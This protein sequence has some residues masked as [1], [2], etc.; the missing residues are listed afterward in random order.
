MMSGIWLLLDCQKKVMQ[1]G[2]L[3]RKIVVF[4]H[5][6]D[7]V[8]FTHV[9]VLGLPIF[10]YYGILQSGGHLLV[11][12]QAIAILYLL[13][14]LIV[15]LE[16][17]AM[18]LCYASGST[19]K[20][21]RGLVQRT[22][23]SARKTSGGSAAQDQKAR[24]SLPRCSLIV[25]AYLPNEQQIILSTLQHILRTIERP[26]DGLEVILAY[27]TP[28]KL[29]VEDDLQELAYQYPELRLLYVARS[30][31]KAENLN[32]AIQ[33]AT[34]EITGILDAD[35]LP[36]PGC[37]GRAW[38]W[39]QAGAYDVVQGRN[40]IRNANC[41]LLTRL[42]AVEFECLYGVSHP[43]KSLLVDTGLFSGSNGYWL[44]SV[45]RRIRFHPQVMTEDVD[46]TLQTLLA[47]HRIVHDPSIM[48][49][50]LAPPD[51]ASF[52]SQRK[53]WAQGWLEVT[54]K[55]QGRLLRSAKLDGWQKLYWTLL[56]LHSAAFHLIALQVFPI[57]L[58]LTLSRGTV[59]ALNHN[60]VSLLITG[61]ILIS[62][63]LQTWAA[64]RTRNPVIQHPPSFFLLYGLALPFYCILKN[65]IAIAATYDYLR[66]D[67]EWVVTRRSP[68]S[69]RALTYA[70]RLP[71]EAIAVDQDH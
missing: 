13:T 35:H 14:A 39:L 63:P 27:N 3:D 70:K 25:V 34:G 47:G 22:L 67:N 46:A 43:A 62:G 31:S 15:I 59:P 49:T 16:S 40:V 9:V 61:L 12:Q 53:R 33:I 71:A 66:G 30:K 52:W 44:T 42:I 10:I 1:K 69:R 38:Y 21:R 50:E 58:S 8:I 7:Q 41:T 11:L 5:V 29:P 56:M 60:S 54:F 24:R 32:A 20:R 65:I 48:A 23:T 57:F 4:G 37:L 6:L 45:L 19:C 28:V 2:F 64:M 55:Y 68:R 51:F 18:L 17:T 26:R 36:Q